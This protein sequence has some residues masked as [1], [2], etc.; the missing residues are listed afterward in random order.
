MRTIKEYLNMF[1]HNKAIRKVLV[2]RILYWTELFF[3]TIYKI[4]VPFIPAIVFGFFEQP[5][6]SFL[7]LIGG[8]L[9]VSYNMFNRGSIKEIYMQIRWI[10]YGK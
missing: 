2:W 5:F 6:M 8:L 10:R 4:I 9:R 7:L 3:N 1:I